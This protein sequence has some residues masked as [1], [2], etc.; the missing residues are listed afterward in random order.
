M[1]E[2]G[3]RGVVRQ[4]QP[5]CLGDDSPML[6][7]Y[8]I[9]REGRREVWGWRSE[10][11]NGL[12]YSQDSI[13]TPLAGSDGGRGRYHRDKTGKKEGGG[14]EKGVKSGRVRLY[15]TGR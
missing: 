7:I 11:A 10:G 12:G 9:R 14:T 8:S 4:R 15:I 3:R 5:I 6:G 1:K 13:I 2:R